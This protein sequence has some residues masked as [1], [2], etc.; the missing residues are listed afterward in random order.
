VAAEAQAFLDR[1]TKRHGECRERFAAL[2]AGYAK[3]LRQAKRLV[4]IS[5]RS[6]RE[7]N[8]LNQRLKESEEKYRVIFENMA[9]GIFQASPDGR[10]LEAN[11]A[12]A[13]TLGYASSAEMV[14][15]LIQGEVPPPLNR[16]QWRQLA[17]LLDRQGACDGFET[18][19]AKRDGSFIQA[20]IS[21]RVRRDGCGSVLLVEGLVMD[22][23]QRRLMEE[24]LRILAS[25]DGLTGLPNRR[26]FMD[27]GRREFERA[28]RHGLDLTA[29]MIDVDH[30]KRVNDTRG[31]E[32]G[33]QVLM[34]L[35]RAM[36]AAL[37]GHDLIGR[38]GGEEFAVLLVETPLPE[39][40]AVA[41]RL[42][43]SLAGLAVEAAAGR[44]L[45]CT[46]SLGAAPLRPAM[47]SLDQ[48]LGDA[49][50]ALYRAKGAGRNCV[51]CAPPCSSG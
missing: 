31:H 29:L 1:G 10:L 13:A 11:P 7:L 19:M 8:S 25:T 23:T 47:T 32:A 44:H 40:V 9:E 33:D 36:K 5:D 49:D 16:E 2:V 26:H 39:G 35:A 14:R 42:R 43:T 22:V 38:M 48:L 27:L 18:R 50:R 24:S 3:L 37:R 41:Q 6:Q 46:V 28:Q 34:A 4:K 15:G 12:L 45:T 20:S 21:A 17:D 30:F 51:M